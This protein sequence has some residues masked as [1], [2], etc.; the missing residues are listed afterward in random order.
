M[1]FVEK[2][3]YE[4][5][6]EL[7]LK[8][9]LDGFVNNTAQNIQVGSI[10]TINPDNRH[11][12]GY[13]MVRFSY[14]PYTLQENKTIDGQVFDFISLV[15]NK[16]Y[17]S[18]NISHSIWYVNPIKGNIKNIIY[19]RNVIKSDISVIKIKFIKELPSCLKN[20]KQE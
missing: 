1:D 14:L 12:H 18:P 7:V 13:Y 2:G 4:N 16:R 8:I 3:T 19:L 6:C 10:C 17:F 9:I 20:T 11:S 15:A 5:E